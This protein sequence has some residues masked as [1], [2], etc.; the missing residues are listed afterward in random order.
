MR[1]TNK[2]GSA[3]IEE[4]VR[5][6]EIELNT[7]VPIGIRR[8]VIN[9]ITKE[10]KETMKEVEVTEFRNGKEVILIGR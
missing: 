6:I 7:R 5:K 1:Y 8:A 3:V 4:A 9:R 10:L 2:F